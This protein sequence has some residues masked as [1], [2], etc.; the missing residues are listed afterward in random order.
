MTAS[1]LV[2]YQTRLPVPAGFEVPRW[3]LLTE[4]IFPNAQNPNV[5]LLAVDYCKVRKLD[6]MKRPVH[7]VPMWNSALRQEIETVWPGINETQITAA[8]TGEWAGM[9][10]AKLG[11]MLTETF[12]GRKKDKTGGWSDAQCTLTFPEYVEVTVYR[13]KD[14]QRCPFTEPVYWREAYG[15]V[16]GTKL[17]N[18]TWQRRTIS[19]L[20]K[21]GKAASLRAAFPE[22]DLGPTAEEMEGHV[23]DEMVDVTAPPEQARPTITHV[24]QPSIDAQATPQALA[25]DDN[26]N[27]T[28]LGNRLIAAV[29][30]ASSND[31]IDEWGR[32][33]KTLLDMMKADA[34]KLYGTVTHTINKHRLSLP[35]DNNENPN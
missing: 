20:I 4:V 16:G 11:P 15:R 32:L 13:M 1:A 33:N 19:Q 31:V 14:G 9:D 2:Q 17:P 3:R 21:C 18:D 34:P 23:I 6:I 30:T 25:K 22:E 24:V 5:I 35:Q 10:R 28:Q 8:R 29:C 27:W 7:I 26:E 12:Q